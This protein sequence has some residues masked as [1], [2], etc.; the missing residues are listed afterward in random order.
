MSNKTTQ[1]A[2][3][4]QAGCA[5]FGDFLE[6]RLFDSRCVRVSYDGTMEPID[7]RHPEDIPLIAPGLVDLQVNGFAG[8]DFNDGNI[9][10]DAWVHAA[11]ALYRERVTSFL[12]TLVTNGVDFVE[13]QLRRLESYR[14][15]AEA[16][17]LPEAARVGGYHLEGPFISPTE[18]YRGAHPAEFVL[19]VRNPEVASILDR[20]QQ[21][22]NGRVLL[23]TF[24]P[25]EDGAED[26]VHQLV[27]RGIL[28]AVGHSDASGEKIHAASRSGAVLATH[29]GNACAQLLPRHANP[30]WSVL[31]DENLNISMIA[32]G[33][34]LPLDMLKVFYR[35]KRERTILVSDATQYA[36][37]EPGAYHTHIGGSV[38]LT[39]ERKLHI[40]GQP[41]VLA[42]AAKSLFEGVQFLWQ[43]GFASEADVW[44]LGSLHPVRLLSGR[45][46]SPEWNRFVKIK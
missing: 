12:P 35:V 22:S 7:T 19:S 25:H 14:L 44:A 9:S 31:A 16:H 3:A 42:G 24:S 21:A 34:H 43:N 46:F 26:F 6:G 18:G 45:D 37:K 30:I 10:Y 15:R 2:G 29:L 27:S 41:N 20:W 36:G 28:A 40:E 4:S 32:D 17:A 33:F 13:E 8:V 5:P 38:V 23:M 39:P 11:Q 1:N